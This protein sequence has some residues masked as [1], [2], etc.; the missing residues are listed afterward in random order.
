MRDHTCVSDFCLAICETNLPLPFQC[1]QFKCNWY[2]KN[3]TRIS[4]YSIH[5][6]LL[7][8]FLK[9]YNCYSQD[10]SHNPVTL[11]YHILVIVKMKNNPIENPFYY[12]FIK[13][14][15]RKMKSRKILIGPNVQFDFAISF[16]HDELQSIREPCR[17]RLKNSLSLRSLNFLSPSVDRIRVWTTLY[18][19]WAFDAIRLKIIVQVKRNV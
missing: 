10:N 18:L 3:R 13:R 16:P 4:I 15:K 14:F 12:H 19:T 8:T 6:F 11:V 1:S 5:C 17:Y 2:L 9:H 7:W